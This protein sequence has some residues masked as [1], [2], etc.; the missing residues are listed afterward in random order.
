[1]SFI[2]KSTF[3]TIIIISFFIFY[4]TIHINYAD[5]HLK[6]K[7]I[8]WNSLKQKNKEIIAQNPENVMANFEL[9]VAMSNLG[10]IKN[11]YNLINE[12]GEKIPINK[13][14]NEI[15]PYLIKLEKDRYNLLLLNYAAFYKL[16]KSEYGEAI[17]YY[18]RISTLDPHN[19]WIMNFMASCYIEINDYEHAEKLILESQQICDSDFSH[20]LR[21]L[22]YYKKGKIVEALIELSKSGELFGVLLSE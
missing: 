16:I 20:L 19:I 2:K 8:D 3:F 12:I 10:E 13:F 4:C 1:M 21:G 14:D 18:K 7:T 17:N 9:I 22:I 5:C 15:K 6:A 11:A